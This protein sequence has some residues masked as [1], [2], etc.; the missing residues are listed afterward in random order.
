M[1]I[2]TAHVLPGQP[3]ACSAS[4]RHA[5]IAAKHPRHKTTP[6][7]IDGISSSTSHPATRLPVHRAPVQ[8][9]MPV[10]QMNVLPLR[11]A[12][13][14]IGVNHPRRP[15]LH[16]LQ[17]PKLMPALPVIRTDR[18]RQRRSR[19]RLLFH[20]SSKSPVAGIRFTTHGA[21]AE[22]GPHSGCPAMSVRC[23]LCSRHDSRHHPESATCRFPAR[24]RMYI[25]TRPPFSSTT[26]GSAYATRFAH[27]A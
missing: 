19:T 12:I 14:G 17:I 11:N 23:I 8:M 7:A 20:T 6:R 4:L 15:I 21:S 3:L 24:F 10:R 16:R 1:A 2:F 22:L 18:R 13:R 26:A 5:L 25:A 9:H 27:I